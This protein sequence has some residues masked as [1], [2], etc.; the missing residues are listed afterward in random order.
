[1]KTVFAIVAAIATTS[2]TAGEQGTTSVLTNQPT[3][4]AATATQPCE[5]A[6]EVKLTP[7]QARRLARQADRQEARECRKCCKC[8]GKKDCRPTAIVVTRTRQAC[9]CN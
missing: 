7:W 9:N 8:E 6:R 1:M 2:A 5:N 4:A 3:P